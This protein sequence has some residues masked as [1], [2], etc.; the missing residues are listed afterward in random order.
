MGVITF[1]KYK[2]QEI[3]SIKDTQYLE[4]V[5]RKAREQY[6]N[7]EQDGFI[8]PRKVYNE[9]LSEL[10]RRGIVVQYQQEAEEDAP[11][12]QFRPRNKPAIDKT[13][14]R[15]EKNN[16]DPFEDN[17]DVAIPPIPLNESNEDTLVDIISFINN[18]IEESNKS[19]ST[20]KEEDVSQRFFYSGAVWAFNTVLSYV[21]MLK[22]WNVDNE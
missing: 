22:E 2:G 7:N 6:D 10:R 9:V 3:S 21:E 1:G 14:P 19:M 5:V 15:A 13:P 8:I 4:W 18:M 17:A 20:G 12:R 11:K 16:Y